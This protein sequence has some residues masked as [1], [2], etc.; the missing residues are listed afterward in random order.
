MIADQLAKIQKAL[1]APKGQTNE[2]GH[3][4]Y[5]SCEDI[6]EVVKPL[7][8]DAAL[9][10][11]DEVVQVGDRIYIKA[12]AHLTTY[13]EGNPYS[14]SVT[15]WAREQESRKGMDAAQI[16]GC[17]SSYA[18][19]YCLQ[20]LFLCDSGEN[21]PD[22]MPPQDN[23]G[24][25]DWTPPPKGGPAPAEEPP[26][27]EPPPAEPPPPATPPKGQ[28]PAPSPSQ[29]KWLS[30]LWDYYVIESAG[31]LQSVDAKPMQKMCQLCQMH[32]HRYPGSMSDVEQLKK[33]ITVAELCL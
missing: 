8:G 9:T 17:C 5:R 27:A 12:T 26:P 7:L 6:L 10:I 28:I 20:G 24:P 32:M 11:S 15:G 4:K 18:R 2:F 31:K 29:R 13:F 3:Y 25:A 23:G 1:K 19:K 14:I 30:M 22:T 16:T 33:W 21:D